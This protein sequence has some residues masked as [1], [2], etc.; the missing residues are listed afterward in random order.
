MWVQLPNNNREEEVE[1]INLMFDETCEFNEVAKKYILNGMHEYNQCFVTIMAYILMWIHA[2]EPK[3]LN[4]TDDRLGYLR[5]VR[6]D[7][8]E[9][10]IEDY[11]RW[12]RNAVEEQETEESRSVY[13]GWIGFHLEMFPLRTYMGY[14]HPILFI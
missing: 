11:L 12:Y 13:R 5:I 2:R 7:R 3:I 6:R 10:W 9:E 1:P 14:K 8:I 4:L